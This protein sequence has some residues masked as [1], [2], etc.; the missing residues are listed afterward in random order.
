MSKTKILPDSKLMFIV[1]V[2][3][4]AIVQQ[5]ARPKYCTV[6]RMNA[7]PTADANSSSQ[8]A[9]DQPP[10]QLV[11]FVSYSAI[12]TVQNDTELRTAVSNLQP[13][14]TLKIAPGVYRGGQTVQ[15]IDGLTI[16]AADPQRSP[17]FQGGANA[18]HFSNCSNLT[19]R[20][21]ICKEQT[22]NGLN[23]DD[24]GKAKAATNVTLEKLQVIDIGPKG[25]HDGIKLSGLDGFR[26][27]EC[28]I[29]GW[30]GQGIDMV[31]C[32]DGLI[33]KCRFEG[34]EGFSASAGVQTKGGSS[35]IIV[36]N[37]KFKD[38][39]E[40]PLNIGGSTGL[41]YF[42]PKD[43]KYEAARIVA[44]HN[45][46]EGSLCAVA[47]VGVD[48][49]EFEDNEIL[50]PQKWIFRVLQET[51]GERFVPCRNVKVVNNRITFRRAEVQIEANI[52]AGTQAE[53][54]QFRGNH[55]HAVDRPDRSHPKLP[56]KEEDGHYGVP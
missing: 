8:Y 32:R 45:R 36:E 29:Q 42:R 30:G 12:I 10:Q 41:D 16:E 27:T 1:V 11:Q 7:P 35:D 6:C 2:L 53:T 19:V 22:G 51:T 21:L 38:A 5:L 40:R 20:N 17:I 46:I 18:W 15:G 13:N 9:Y 43:A 14:S 54:F 34:K 24:G 23:L 4:F 28:L 44:R 47:F 37:C 33:D 31:G 52:G 3:A 50:Y 39:G 26:V 48:G 56:V 25:N 55:W 49:A